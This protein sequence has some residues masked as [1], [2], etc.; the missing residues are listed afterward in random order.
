MP[1]RGPAGTRPKRRLR[2]AY[3][4]N[5]LLN[6]SA[7]KSGCRFLT[8]P[9]LI[10]R[11]HVADSGR[12]G[13]LLTSWFQA[14]SAGKTGQPPRVVPAPALRGLTGL[15]TDE[16]DF[17]GLDF[18]LALGAAA[19]LRSGTNDNARLAPASNAMVA[20]AVEMRG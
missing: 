20:F 19:A 7:P 14:L 10:E 4:S 17:V 5:A 6:A 18:A 3:S 9:P 16:T 13:R 8:P 2:L 1:A 12:T 15:P 11:N